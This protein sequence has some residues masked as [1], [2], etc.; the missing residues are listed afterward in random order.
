MYG[1]GKQRGQLRGLT[2]SY[3]SRRRV[4][5]LLNLGSKEVNKMLP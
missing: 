1:K 2:G 3:V 4:D 5:D